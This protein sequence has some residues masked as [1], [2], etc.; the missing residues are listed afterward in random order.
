MARNEFQEI[1]GGLFA[2]IIFFIIG[3]VIISSLG[4]PIGLNGLFSFIFV[5][6]AAV[7]VMAIIVKIINF[8]GFDLR[9]II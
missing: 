9:S 1:V 2:I 5:I 7:I 3:G 4:D 6:G 8:L